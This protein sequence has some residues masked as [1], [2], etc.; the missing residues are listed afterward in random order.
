M[1]LIMRKF[2][3][4]TLFL[5][6]YILIF[7]DIS[8]SQKSGKGTG[9]VEINADSKVPYIFNILK[10]DL[11]DDNWHV[12]VDGDELTAFRFGNG[13]D[14]LKIRIEYLPDDMFYIYK[15][16]VVT[17]KV[18]NKEV[19]IN[20][21]RAYDNLYL[22]DEI[23]S[24][25]YS[26]INSGFNGNIKSTANTKKV[27]FSSIS[28]GYNRTHDNYRFYPEYGQGSFL[29]SGTLVYD[30][31]INVNS[32]EIDL[33]PVDYLSVEFYFCFDSRVREN[34]FNID[35]MIFG[36]NKFE[37]SD[38]AAS[39][40]A[41]YGFFNGFEYFRPG[42]N[43]WDV[44]WNRKIYKKQPHVQY[45]IWRA[46]QWKMINTY[47]VNNKNFISYFSAGLGP[48]INSS[49]TATDVTPEEEDDLSH[50]FKSIKYRKQNYYYGISMP[51][52]AGIVA[53]RIN[54]FKFGA[55]Y[56]LYIFAPVEHEK[57][58]DVLNIVKLSAGY[59]FT[60]NFLLDLHYEYWNIYSM[61]R[62]T[63]AA[64]WWNRIMIECKFLY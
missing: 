58:I 42:W 46:A 22:K 41:L 7:A 24:F 14:E 45:A 63:E 3:L 54:D 64:H 12:R 19:K 13:I 28:A 32:S 9:T 49:L 53:D 10:N 29:M 15:I 17:D 35:L 44:Q 51:L 40:R 37:S 57:A 23:L 16:T 25:V 43:N 62:D 20:K 60:D 33:K 2:I 59:Y 8:Y 50:I 48:S 61:V 27:Y 56:N 5:L 31:A 39:R 52:S 38:S 6:F 36:K 21:S 34:Y 47:T 26:R 4:L 18:Y 30:P 55:G 1:F 11:K